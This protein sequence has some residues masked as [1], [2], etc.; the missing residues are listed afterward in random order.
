[1]S[2]PR[3]QFESLAIAE[4]DSLYRMARRLTHNPAT[5]E[6]L[7]Q[8]TFARALAGRES[9]DLLAFGMK[10][11]LLRI[12][13]NLH[14][15]RVSREKR[16]PISLSEG[17]LDSSNLYRNGNYSPVDPTSFEAMDE[18]VVN[19]LDRLHPDYRVIMLLWAVEELSYKEI[20][21]TLDIPMGTVMSRLHRARSRLA[22]LLQSFATRQGLL[23][24]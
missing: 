19:A 17:E 13:Y 4:L 9:F 6:D 22:D 5:S 15:N 2:L 21:A 12:L 20:S 11:W 24:E 3:E 23:R 8:E 16:M 7:V 10:P 14:L 1:M 18:E